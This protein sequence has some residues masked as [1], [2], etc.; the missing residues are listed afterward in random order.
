MTKHFL[1][2]VSDPGKPHLYH[3]AARL[4]YL[5]PSLTFAS[6][7]PLFPFDF[8]SA[9]SADDIAMAPKR[10]NQNSIAAVIPPIDLNS[11]LP[12]TGNHMSVVSESDLLRL[13]SIGVLPPK[14]LGS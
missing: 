8:A 4:Y 14:E 5:S 6:E 13:V 2:T 3:V 11:Q 7:P 12:F 10:K 1:E 9:Q